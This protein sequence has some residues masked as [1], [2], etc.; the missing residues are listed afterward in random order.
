MP[1]LSPLGWRISIPFSPREAVPR[2]GNQRKKG[3]ILRLSPDNGFRGAKPSSN[4]KV[5][6][7]RYP[8]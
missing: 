6:N 2:G 3:E 5:T 8:Y 4:Y 1:A 7:T